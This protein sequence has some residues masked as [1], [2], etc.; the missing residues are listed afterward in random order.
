M[1]LHKT[2]HGKNTINAKDIK[3]IFSPCGVCIQ[4]NV[5]SFIVIKINAL[6]LN[7]YRTSDNS[8]VDVKY[9][10]ARKSDEKELYRSDKEHSDD[11]RCIA[12]MEAVPMSKLQHKI[13]LTY[14]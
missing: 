11:H 2:A 13:Y 4:R 9:I 3:L 10:L 12:G 6:F 5:A 1:K 8:C 7:N 14:L